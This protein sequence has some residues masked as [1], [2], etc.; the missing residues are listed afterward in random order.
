MAI[1]KGLESENMLGRMAVEG[2][3]SGAGQAA[4]DGG[5]MLIEGEDKDVLRDMGF[6][7]A[8]GAVGGGAHHAG[9]K[10]F[11]SVSGTHRKGGLA[12]FPAFQQIAIDGLI[13]GDFNTINSETAQDD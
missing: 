1:G 8:G 7:G 4:A 11:E 6:S 2:V 10:A 9:D 13:Y 3:G 5:E 12:H